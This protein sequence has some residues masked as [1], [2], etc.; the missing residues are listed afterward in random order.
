MYPKTNDSAV[1][2]YFLKLILNSVFFIILVLMHSVNFMG[3]MRPEILTAVFIIS[4]FSDLIL[5]A[6]VGLNPK[7]DQFG[8]KVFSIYRHNTLL[9]ISLIQSLITG[10]PFLLSLGFLHLFVVTNWLMFIAL[11]LGFVAVKVII[12][13]IY[14]RANYQE[15]TGTAY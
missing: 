11:G 9:Q 2:S 15:V 5:N 10:L 14:I 8:N 13:L 6:V 3:V 7:D 1:G 4:F 12:L